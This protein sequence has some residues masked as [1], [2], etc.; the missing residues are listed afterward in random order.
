MRAGMPG[1]RKRRAS[2]P[3]RRPHGPKN[4]PGEVDAQDPR[5]VPADQYGE[6]RLVP[7]SIEP[8]EEVGVGPIVR[9][10]VLLADVPAEP[11]AHS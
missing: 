6:R 3:D 4:S 8:D 5:P 10:S 7:V 2:S 9:G 1:K 11:S